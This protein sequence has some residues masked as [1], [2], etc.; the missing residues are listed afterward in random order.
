M[1]F[2]Y[3]KEKITANRIVELAKEALTIKIKENKNNIEEFKKYLDEYAHLIEMEPRIQIMPHIIAE[4]ENENEL[5]SA[6]EII[7]I[8]L[9]EILGEDFDIFDTIDNSYIYDVEEILGED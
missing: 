8:D 6:P 4:D 1:K 3:A 2:T 5:P 7:K 9:K